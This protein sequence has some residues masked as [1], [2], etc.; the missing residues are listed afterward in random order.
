MI[1]KRKMAFSLIL[2]IYLSCVLFISINFPPIISDMPLATVD[3]LPQ[4]AI[5]VF[6]DHIRIAFDAGYGIGQ[7]A[8][9]FLCAWFLYCIWDKL[10]WC[11]GKYKCSIVFLSMLFGII[12][13]LGLSMYWLD[14]LPMFSSYIWMCGS[15]FL[16]MGWAMF[17]FACS[18]LLL[19]AF[20]MKLL[21]VQDTKGDIQSEKVRRIEKHFFWFSFFVILLAW[22]PWVLS[23]YP[24]SMDND[25]FNQLNS[26]LYEHNNHHPWFSTCVL[27]ICYKI[28]AKIGSDNLG[29]FIYV[30]GRD[31]IL[32]LIYAKCV[33]MQRELGLK[34][35]I[36]YSTLIFF[37]F[38]P[39]W[40][41]YAKHA[42]K[43]TFSAG[44]FCLYIMTLIMIVYQIKKH[45]LDFKT[46]LLHGASALFAALF[47][48]NCIYAVFPATVILI[49]VMLCKKQRIKYAVT[50]LLCVLFYFGYNHYIFNYKEVKPGSSVEALSIPFQQT[51]RTVKYY[52]NN[53]TKEEIEGI[54]TLFQYDLLAELYNPILSDPVKNVGVLPY[55]SRTPHATT[56]YLKTWA[57]MF[58]RYSLPYFEAAIGQ[59]YGYY[60]F[61]PNLPEQ[62]GNWNSG[63]TVFDW[64]GCNGDFDEN[65][66]FHFLESFSVPRQVLHAWAKVWD[67]IPI[68]CLTDIC[69]LY[70]WLIVLIFYYLLTKKYFIKT[71]PI[72]AVGVMILTC[73]ASPVNDCF[74]Y[75]IPVAAS[76]PILFTL[77][78]DGEDE[79]E[80]GKAN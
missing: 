55:E 80:K 73:V 51:A 48:N 4:N 22:V 60:A 53:L 66:Q 61:T 7:S 1:S 71:I 31:I 41:A 46:C 69:A 42:F 40:G 74:R 43:D 77:L 37:A 9:A 18:S 57:K 39:I 6:L 11:F 62:S 36:Y 2:G 23:Y 13:V 32:A 15:L 14:C 3:A 16:A 44:L 67:K 33:V 47:R 12:N 34:R 38:V 35:I 19:Y 56:I 26:Y 70:T 63:M 59:S 64:I 21:I 68:L 52:G 76:L 27:G 49:C 30:L 25:V 79:V 50:I 10:K 54:S 8:V 65:F 29:I 58:G 72:I 75:F 24:A 20:E 28:G 17:F 45:T 5:A 78:T